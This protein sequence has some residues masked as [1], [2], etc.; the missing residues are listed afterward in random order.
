MSVSSSSC[1]HHV[2][3]ANC[4]YSHQF[5]ETLFSFLHF[6]WQSEAHI[7]SHIYIRFFF[8]TVN[9]FIS[10]LIHFYMQNYLYFL[11]LSLYSVQT[12]SVS[13]ILSTLHVS[14]TQWIE[15]LKIISF[16]RYLQLKERKLAAI[17]II[18]VNGGRNRNEK[19]SKRISFNDNLD[20]SKNGKEE[21]SET[22]F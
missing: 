16:K 9:L 17:K 14:N 11:P 2:F 18:K 7:T 8:H 10:K 6:R 22:K 19:E 21:K 3:S 15:R 1:E 20:C 4:V 5:V 13:H 12:I